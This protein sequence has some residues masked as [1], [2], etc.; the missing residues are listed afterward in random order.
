MWKDRIPPHLVEEVERIVQDLG[1]TLG[2]GNI[3]GSDELTNERDEAEGAAADEDDDGDEAPAKRGIGLTLIFDI[4]RRFAQP[5]IIDTK[6]GVVR[7]LPVTE[8]ALQLFG[9]AGADAMATAIENDPRKAA[10]LE[11]FPASEKDC[12]QTRS[13]PLRR[14]VHHC[15][16]ELFGGAVRA[17]AP[18]AA[19][20]AS[21][22]IWR[23]KS[24][25]GVSRLS[26]GSH[27]LA[28]ENANAGG[29][30]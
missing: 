15:G 16:L 3:G 7:L 22:A 11:L 24:I 10:Q 21:P 30:N 20:P 2:A 25:H 18:N 4:V 26:C 23:A 8:R 14:P 13:L 19:T 12:S 28:D 6:K 5:L 29:W 1:R 17:E 27:A 9:A